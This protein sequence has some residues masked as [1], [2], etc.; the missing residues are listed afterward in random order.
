MAVRSLGLGEGDGVAFYDFDNIP[1]TRDY[2]TG[3]YRRLNGL[4]LSDQEKREIVD[5]ANYVF[6]LNIAI[7][8]ELEGS[9][10][11]AMW[12]L[13]FNSLKLKFGLN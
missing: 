11:K 4:K 9:P 12:T 6:A 1:N 8:E 5:E 3:W 7:F 2:I 13:P 10:F